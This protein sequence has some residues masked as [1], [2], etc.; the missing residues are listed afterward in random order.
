M[1]P[2]QATASKQVWSLTQFI[3]FTIND[4]CKKGCDLQTNNHSF[5]QPFL[6]CPGTSLPSAAHL[7]VSLHLCSSGSNAQDKCRAIEGRSVSSKSPSM[8]QDR[9][10]GG[11]GGTKG[12]SA[13]LTRGH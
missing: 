13:S 3:P 4:R 5:R 7:I 2:H 8:V 12:N 11:A 9:D 10:E 6:L 1:S